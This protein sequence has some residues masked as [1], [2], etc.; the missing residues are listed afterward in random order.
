VTSKSAHVLLVCICVIHDVRGSGSRAAEVGV[1]EHSTSV[2]S[3]RG[4]PPAEGVR[5]PERGWLPGPSSRRGQRVHWVPTDNCVTWVFRGLADPA[6][7]RCGP[8]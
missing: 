8:V 5:R 4:A 2:R 1:G 3:R 7:I 6:V